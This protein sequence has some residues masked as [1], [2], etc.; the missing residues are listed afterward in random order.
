MGDGAL[1]SLKILKVR[2]A[3]E[4]GAQVLRVERALKA[5]PAKRLRLIDSSEGPENLNPGLLPFDGDPAG[6]VLIDAIDGGPSL[7]RAACSQKPLRDLNSNT[8]SASCLLTLLCNE[9]VDIPPRIRNRL[10]RQSDNAAAMALSQVIGL[11][12]TTHTPA[13]DLAVFDTRVLPRLL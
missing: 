8:R 4:I 6:S 9:G 5:G 12:G 7:L 2:Q 13:D 11:Q 1:L 10:Q 3:L